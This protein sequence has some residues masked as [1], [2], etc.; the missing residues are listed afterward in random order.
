M[1]SSTFSPQQP[2]EDTLPKTE[3]EILTLASLHLDQK[4]KKPCQY[5]TERNLPA[6]LTNGSKSKSWFSWIP[7][8]NQDKKINQQRQMEEEEKQ[9]HNTWSE[10]RNRDKK[11]NHQNFNPSNGSRNQ[12]DGTENTQMKQKKILTNNKKKKKKF[13]EHCCLYL[14]SDEKKNEIWPLNH[15][16]NTINSLLCNTTLQQQSQQTEEEMERRNLRPANDPP[17][18]YQN[19]TIGN[20]FCK[21]SLDQEDISDHSSQKFS[22]KMSEQFQQQPQLQAALSYSDVVRMTGRPTPTSSHGQSHRPYLKRRATSPIHC[23]STSGAQHRHNLDIPMPPSYHEPSASHQ[24]HEEIFDIEA[25]LQEAM[26]ENQR[27]EPPVRPAYQTIQNSAPPVITIPDVDE[28]GSRYHAPPQQIRIVSVRSLAQLLPRS[29]NPSEECDAWEK[30]ANCGGAMIHPVN[31]CPLRQCLK[32]AAHGHLSTE[33]P[34]TVWDIPYPATRMYDCP[35]PFVPMNGG[36]IA[37]PRWA[38]L[39]V[40]PRIL[41]HLYRIPAPTTAGYSQGRPRSFHISYDGILRA[42]DTT[43][44]AIPLHGRLKEIRINT[45][46]PGSRTLADLQITIPVEGCNGLLNQLH[47][48]EMMQVRPWMDD[49]KHS[50]HLTIGRSTTSWPAGTGMFDNFCLATAL[51]IEYE[52]GLSDRMVEISIS[53]ESQILTQ[54]SSSVHVPWIQLMQIRARLGCLLEEWRLY[55]AQELRAMEEIKAAMYPR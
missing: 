9:R 27:P 29:Q 3:E 28:C 40:S 39:E 51:G 19:W 24:S 25:M 38:Y 18:E 8:L 52:D 15:S 4:K 54:E 33:C 53:H 10:R 20:S 1:K 17:V 26:E 12:S 32:C 31:Q 7:F 47:N 5:E 36:S 35:L 30:C 13:V 49:G 41:N 14:Y 2:F 44:T 43:I 22:N 16:T 37:A 34:L 50:R 11:K 42:Q 46:Y 45:H 55:T 6:T 21:I 23:P 48:L